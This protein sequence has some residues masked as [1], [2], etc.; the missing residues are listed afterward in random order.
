[1]AEK[2][3]FSIEVEPGMKT[4]DTKVYENE[5]EQHIDAI[6]GDI[7]FI[8]EQK[9]HPTFKRVGDN[10]YVNLDIELQEAL[11]GFS[12]TITHLDGHLV[13]VTSLPNEIIQPFSWKIIP[14]EGMPKRG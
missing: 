12:K 14:N 10:L 8:I 5:G 11:L 1:V 9:V 4:G 6:Q 7:T 3:L 13:T 2:K